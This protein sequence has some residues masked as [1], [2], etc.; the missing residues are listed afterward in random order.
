MHE[1]KVPADGPLPGELSARRDVSLSPAA[2]PCREQ[3]SSSPA[4]EG[5]ALSE[6]SGL[7]PASGGR[8]SATGSSLVTT[9]S[10]GSRM[11]PL[12]GKHY[13]LDCHAQPRPLEEGQQVQSGLGEGEFCLVCKNIFDRRPDTDFQINALAV[14]SEAC[15]RK[16]AVAYEAHALEKRA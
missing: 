4:A 14:C 16:Y 6:V 9:I 15:L 10:S 12:Q 11:L 3:Q 8:G 5:R 13:A 1:T 7:A 2:P